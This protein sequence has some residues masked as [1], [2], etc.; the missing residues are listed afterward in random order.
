MRVNGQEDDRPPLQQRK[1]A[2]VHRGLQCSY[3]GWHDRGYKVRGFTE[4]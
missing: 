3:G 1:G 4:T 2:W